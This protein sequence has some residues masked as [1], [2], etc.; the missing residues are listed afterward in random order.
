MIIREGVFKLERELKIGGS[1]NLE[2]LAVTETLKKNL[3]R[4]RER[5][6]E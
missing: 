5:E 1:L 6:R 2:G 4:K 3:K